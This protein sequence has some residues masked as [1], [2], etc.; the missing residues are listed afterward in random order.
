MQRPPEE[1][2]DVAGCGGMVVDLFY[3]TPRIARADEKILLDPKGD[4]AM[5]LAA[6][7][8]VVLN[9]L[10]WPRILGLKAG[11][12]GKMGDEADGKFLRDGMEPPGIRNHLTL[13]GRP[14]T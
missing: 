10:G 12:S 6:V 5:E 7:G 3:R 2:L 9:H 4:S 11:I 13:Y 8:G 14:G 1:K